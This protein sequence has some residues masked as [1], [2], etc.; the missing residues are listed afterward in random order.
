MLLQFC[1]WYNRECESKA[2]SSWIIDY[3]VC[4]LLKKKTRG[5][6]KLP[7]ILW[8]EEMQ[9]RNGQGIVLKNIQHN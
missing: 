5:P 4:S 1:Q 8:D 9:A 6:C 7:V 2:E 3:N